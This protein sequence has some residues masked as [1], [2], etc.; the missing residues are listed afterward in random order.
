MLSITQNS[1]FLADYLG[2]AKDNN[3][4]YGSQITN[5]SSS[6]HQNK[7]ITIL[8]AEGDRVTLSSDS[9]CQTSYYDYKGLI[10]ER[11][12]RAEL[13][14]S[15][16]SVDVNQELSITIEGDLSEEEIQDIQKSIKM[17]DKIMHQALSGNLGPAL[18]MIHGISSMESISGFSADL[19][20]E[21]IVSF[22]QQTA[23]KAQTA[24]PVSI[25]EILSDQ[26]ALSNDRS[27][28]ALNTMLESLEH[29]KGFKN[30]KLI[31]PLNKYFSKIFDG[32]SEKYTGPEKSEK[33]R[34]AHRIYSEIFKQIGREAQ[35][36]LIKNSELESGQVIEELPE[37]VGAEID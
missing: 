11:H 26:N 25:T 35:E 19:V 14:L 23:F 33:M 32:I 10:N 17:I 31:K 5:I 3:T 15:R 9:T 1:N 13:Q 12:A 21:N 37:A 6:Q 16:Y 4:F 8:T 30:K 29:N 22:E 2:L 27:D 7:D 24:A 18:T 28:T 34:I 20:I 36:D